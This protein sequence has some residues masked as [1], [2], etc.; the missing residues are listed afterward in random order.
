MESDL[1]RFWDK[2]EKTDSCWIWKAHKLKKGYGHFH[3]ID[4]DVL[5]HR[6]SYELHKGKIPE[7]L[8]VCHSCDSP[9]CVNPD[10]L[11]LGTNKENRD[12]AECKG[13]A[14]YFGFTIPKKGI[15]NNKHKLTETQVIEIRELKKTGKSYRKIAKQYNV[16]WLTIFNLVHR[17]TW[18]HI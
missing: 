12:D 15:E 17:K 2:V 10:H 13:R 5:A 18:K 11:W 6:F 4:K 1:K 7:G 3:F 16:F 8:F 14:K 9:S